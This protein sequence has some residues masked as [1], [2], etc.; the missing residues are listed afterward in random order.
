MN[1]HNHNLNIHYSLPDEYWERLA[2]LYEEMPQWS[3]YL[4]GVP[5]WFANERNEQI[6][7]VSVEPSGLQFYALLPDEEWAAWFN[8][9]KEK[10]TTVLGFEVGEP[11]DGI[12]FFYV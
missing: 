4:N 9:F 7:E 12:E 10:A 6:I 3:G 1:H 5:T 8:L 11:E 2:K